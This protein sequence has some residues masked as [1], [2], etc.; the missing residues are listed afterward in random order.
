M[1]WNFLPLIIRLPAPQGIG[2]PS[3]GIMGRWVQ[4]IN[5]YCMVG[6]YDF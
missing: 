1:I 3:N 6:D 4:K 5:Y 2:E